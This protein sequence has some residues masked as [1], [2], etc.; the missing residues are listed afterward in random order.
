MAD[1]EWLSTPLGRLGHR[2]AARLSPKPFPAPSLARIFFCPAIHFSCLPLFFFGL[3]PPNIMPTAGLRGLIRS[4]SH[5]QFIG[6]ALFCVALISCAGCFQ[7]RYEPA[8]WES[9]AR[10]ATKRKPTVAAAPGS[11]TSLPGDRTASTTLPPKSGLP[12]QPAPRGNSTR[13]NS[14]IGNNTGA[15]STLPGRSTDR[16]NTSLPA[17]APAGSGIESP[18]PGRAGTT[19]PGRN[20][21]APGNQTTLPGRKT[22]LPGRKTGTG[23]ANSN[24][25]LPG[26]NPVLPNRNSGTT[27]PG[28]R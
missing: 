18:L 6:A 3:P 22:E 11:G 9:K 27:L 15:A 5:P 12:K 17:R 8:N 7:Q 28:R 23:Q 10:P 26:R 16:G 25:T 20:S 1:F 4:A 24:T 14:A 13:G 21:A 2:V 19:L